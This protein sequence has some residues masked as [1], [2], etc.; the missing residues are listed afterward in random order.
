[1]MLEICPMSRADPVF[2]RYQVSF[3]IGGGEI[4]RASRPILIRQTCNQDSPGGQFVELG[5]AVC[6]GYD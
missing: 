5:V 4:K 2:P 6:L 1:M 3:L